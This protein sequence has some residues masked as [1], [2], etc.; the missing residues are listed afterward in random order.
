MLRQAA[1]PAPGVDRLGVEVLTTALAMT[2]WVAAG[3][4]SLAVANGLGGH[5]ARRLV[6][7]IVLCALPAVAL[8]RRWWVAS[9][10]RR[11]PR[12]VVV[13]AVLVAVLVAVDGP[14]DGSFAAVS[15]CVLGL[16]VVVAD[17]PIVVACTAILTAGYVGGAVLGRSLSDLGDREIAGLVSQAL[18][19]PFVAAALLLVAGLLRNLLAETA[20]TVDG[21]LSER[22]LGP[23]PGPQALLASID[24]FSR[25]TPTER[26]V[27]DHLGAGLTPKQ[28][29]LAMEQPIG[30]TRVHIKH[31]KKKTGAAT[32]AQ[33]CA[34]AIVREARDED[35]A[36]R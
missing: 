19:Y 20:E 31:I 9:V 2:L 17:R 1:R 32:L 23:G 18:A 35:D 29:A 26:R 11:S 10:L 15:L 28:T 30:T 13:V 33:L 22:A 27:L 3:S 5:P 25:L 16:T 21:T 36:V 6:I 34:M 8:V 7:G 24:P 12:V 14:L 4:V